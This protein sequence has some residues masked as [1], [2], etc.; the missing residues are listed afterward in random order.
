MLVL[1]ASAALP[2]AAPALAHATPHGGLTTTVE[3]PA[4]HVGDSTPSYSRE[5]R[6]SRARKSNASARSPFLTRFRISP[7]TMLMDGRDAVV[8]YRIN[9]RDTK[10]NVSLVVFRGKGKARQ[11]VTKKNLGSRK[12]GVGHI[13]RLK[14]N[15][16][17]PG[18]YRVVI[19]ARDRAGHNLRRVKTRTA[20]AVQVISQKFPVAGSWVW[21]GDGSKF[22]AP[23]KGHTHMGYDLAAP[24]GTPVVAPI[25]G[26][27]K[28]RQ[29]QKGGAGHYL[30]LDGDD[31]FDYAFMHLQTGSLLVNEG[32]RVG[33]GQQ[34]AGVGSTGGSSGPHL[35]FEIWTNGW[36]E[37]DGE[38]IDPEP[39]LRSWAEAIGQTDGNPTPG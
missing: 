22:G 7:K 25:S 21:G 3:G 30:I 12:T 14:G 26:V 2:A 20:V 35:H 9:D 19:R 34:I 11:R 4:G 31:G 13:Y 27:I 37:K 16:F 8:R 6:R 36:W 10:V 5:K 23:R 33:M 39:L 29:Y 15:E 17:E 32:D 28:F 18:Q 1:S 38:P 24:D